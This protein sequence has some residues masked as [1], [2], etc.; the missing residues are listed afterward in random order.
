[1][2]SG[3]AGAAAVSG[4]GEVVESARAV[5]GAVSGQ[6]GAAVSGREAAEG[7]ARLRRN[8]GPQHQ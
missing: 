6:A 3:Q 2:G 5:V 8:R 1:M 7:T 4:P